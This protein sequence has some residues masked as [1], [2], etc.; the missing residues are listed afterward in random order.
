MEIRNQEKYMNSTGGNVKKRIVNE[1]SESRPDEIN[2]NRR[3]EC[4]KEGVYI[5]KS[6]CDLMDRREKKKKRESSSLS[7]KEQ[8]MT[9]PIFLLS[10][11]FNDA[12]L[13]SLM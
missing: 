4:R 1:G 2:V 6:T 5:C 7:K 3:I 10:D 9:W 13:T 8:K 12:S 11:I